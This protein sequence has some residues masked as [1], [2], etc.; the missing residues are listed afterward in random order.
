M[1]RSATPA[2]EDRAAAVNETL[3]AQDMAASTQL[4]TL[5]AGYAEGR[6]LANQMLGQIQMSR[7][8]SK[9][10]DVVSL[11]KLKY[12]KENKSYRALSGQKGFDRHGSE[13]TDVGTWVGFCAALGVSASKV[14][15]D[16]TNLQFFGEEALTQL[17]QA[18]AGY[19][20][21]RQYRKLPDDQKQALIEVA[22]A[23]DK[24]G[25]VELA[26]EIIAKHTKEK[27]AL[28][29]QLDESKKEQE[30]TEKRL[31]VVRKQ[32]EEAEAQAARIAVMA[33][34]EALAD[35]QA[36]ATRIAAD[37]LGAIQ[38]G[39]RQALNKLHELPEGVLQPAFAA[40]LVGQLQA[41][42]NQLRHD[43]GLPDVA[44]AEASQLAAE[45]N[46]WA[47]KK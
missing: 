27:E 6:D 34:D 47:A 20:E 7:A 42:L 36:A 25:F 24:E 15:E 8:I 32:K 2:P 22:K 1:P 19:R 10:T 41:E 18:G 9:F 12:I 13:I 33:P 39:V 21:L 28:A 17:T 44:G 26:E 45:V 16:L 37:A 4:G 5:Q 29:Q 11:Q 38:G 35:L 14:D 46:E 3:I 40:G 23:G 43:F 31:D 30:A